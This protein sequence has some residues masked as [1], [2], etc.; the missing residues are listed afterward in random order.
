MKYLILLAQD[1]SVWPS[2]SAVEREQY[3]AAHKAFGDAVQQRSAALAGEAVAASGAATTMRH[4]GDRTVLTD[5]PYAEAA[6][7]LGGFYLIDV[8]DLDE[9]LQLCELLPH[10]YTIEVRPVSDTDSEAS[11]D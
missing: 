6:E 9:A 1:E 11:E 5:G 7:Q 4:D 3:L 8:P 2:L 10:E